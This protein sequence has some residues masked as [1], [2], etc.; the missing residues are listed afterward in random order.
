MWFLSQPA[1]KDWIDEPEGCL[2][3]SADPGCGKSVLAKALIDHELVR[4]C[5]GAIICYFFFKDQVQNKLCMA[6]CALLHQLFDAEPRLIKHAQAKFHRYGM[7]LQ[8]NAQALF[9]ILTD[10]LT[11]PISV[12]VIFVL[13]AMDECD[14]DDCAKLFRA[15]KTLQLRTKAGTR[16]LKMLLTSRPY[17]NIIFDFQ[18][19]NPSSYLRLSSEPEALSQPG[20]S[21]GDLP[22]GWEARM[23]EKGQMY[24]VDR[25]TG[26]R[27]FEDPRT[28]GL[29][30][31]WGVRYT[32]KGDLLRRYFVDHNTRAST[33]LD[34]RL[35]LSGTPL[36]ALHLRNHAAVAAEGKDNIQPSSTNINSPH[37]HNGPRRIHIPGEL[38]SEAISQEVNLVI[39]Y[40]LQELYQRGTLKKDVR[41]N[42]EK[43][44]LSQTNRTYLWV[45][46]LFDEL[47]YMIKPT[48]KET[49]RKLTM[50]PTSVNEA[51]E[52]ILSRCAVNE[53]IKQHAVRTLCVMLA[54]KRSL[55]PREIQIAVRIEFDPPSSRH[56]DLDLEDDKEFANKLR[57]WCGL[58]VQVWNGR[59]T[60]IHQTARE[61]LLAKKTSFTRTPL[62]KAWRWQG[63]TSLEYAHNI[64]AQC[65]MIYLGLTHESITSL[66]DSRRLKKDWP[67]TRQRIE[68][69]SKIAFLEYAA[70]HWDW[71]LLEG[72]CKEIDELFQLALQT[73]DPDYTACTAWNIVRFHHYPPHRFSHRLVI[74]A[75]LEPKLLPMLLVREDAADQL[76]D[77]TYKRIFLE[78]A[79]SGHRTIMELV[80]SRGIDVNQC[81]D[82]RGN[83]A[84]HITYF[85]SCIE[86][87]LQ[88]GAQIDIQDQKG[89][90]PLLTA[91]VAG[92]MEKV[93]ILLQRGAST[94]IP[95]NGGDSALSCAVLSDEL[96]LV[97]FI[98][99]Y[100]GEVNIQSPQ[101]DT[102]L[103]CAAMVDN[104]PAARLLF[105][106]GADPS[107]QNDD[108]STAQD[109]AAIRGHTEIVEVLHETT[110]LIAR[111]SSL[112]DLWPLKPHWDRAQN[113]IGKSIYNNTGRRRPYKKKEDED[114]A[115]TASR[116]AFLNLDTPRK[117]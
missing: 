68:L 76:D 35:P 33:W 107:I 106:N 34:P 111:R 24:F 69:V 47:Q 110:K 97:Q 86:F 37:Y 75:S 99:E 46:F 15:L 14:D 88:R 94:T 64:I 4:A 77:T 104:P 41:A 74:A 9:E 18:P 57:N 42:L 65:C 80:L 92:D 19:D 17:H 16:G 93:K 100:G 83:T 3:V 114:T 55:S 84:L 50:L 22:K 91:I 103:H 105:N 78:A 23:T 8:G 90:T 1:Y 51:Y 62:L 21:I 98:L 7:K 49:E 81:I 25:N 58:F 27:T 54:A 29:P 40:R 56:E 96:D 43:Q 5:P 112:S 12:P 89:Y 85:L 13:D 20:S 38:E 73:C 117:T 82:Q 101:G 28:E 61:F 108:G 36:D 2:L 53:E 45:Y 44:L 70:Q 109:L 52:G 102:A 63:F 115:A 59:V 6:L 26:L 48:W 116:L 32:K 87:L 30:V 67:R 79:R 11:D 60:F 10:A 66:H 72:N 71:H 31:G 39:R 113:G 95:D